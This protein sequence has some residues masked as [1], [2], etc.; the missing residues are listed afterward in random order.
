MATHLWHNGAPLAG[1][2]LVLDPTTHLGLRYGLGLFETLG[3]TGHHGIRL[4]AF[5]QARLAQGLVKLLGFTLPAA[6]AW[7]AGRWAEIEHALGSLQPPPVY[8]SL[9]LWVW[10]TGPMGAYPAPTGTETLLAITPEPTDPWG[11]APAW[12]LAYQMG[13]SPV[14]GPLRGLKLTSAAHYALAAAEAQYLGYDD[15]LLMGTSGQVAETARAN[16]YAYTGQQWLTPPAAAG[17]VAGTV[18]AALLAMAEAGQVPLVEGPLT[19]EALWAAEAVAVSN[20]RYGLVAVAEVHGPQGQRT[21]PLH[22]AFG[23]LG[24]QLAQ[25]VAP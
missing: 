5:H 1:P 12:R 20:A 15:A 8:A 10:A 14:T 25:R 11:Q 24:R 21:Y 6:E 4:A 7:V 13:Y 17:L 2:A 23:A 9:R 3:W 18:R 16:L 19:P 22:P